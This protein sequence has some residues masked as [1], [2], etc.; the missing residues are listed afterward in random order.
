MSSV[1][2]RY[3]LKH[4]VLN[5]IKIIFFKNLLMKKLNHSQINMLLNHIG[6]KPSG[7]YRRDYNVIKEFMNDS[8]YRGRR[9]YISI[10]LWIDGLDTTPTPKP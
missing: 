5:K 4:R 1:S 10:S 2:Y 3:K 9:D 6:R 8:E 7:I